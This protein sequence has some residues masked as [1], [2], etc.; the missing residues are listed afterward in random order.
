MGMTAHLAI[1]TALFMKDD[2]AGLT[3]EAKLCLSPIDGALEF[4]VADFCPFG[5]IEAQRE[6]E[7]LTLGSTGS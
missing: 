2:G 4:L 3:C 1:I 7:L 5:R 6:Q